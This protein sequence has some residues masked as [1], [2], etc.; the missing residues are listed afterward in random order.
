[1]MTNLQP[2][3]SG[4]SVNFIVVSDAGKGAWVAALRGQKANSD[5]AAGVLHERHSRTRRD[6]SNFYEPRVSAKR[7]EFMY[8]NAAVEDGRER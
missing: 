8:L 7:A 4:S 2:L 1:M 3:K 5:N 6:H